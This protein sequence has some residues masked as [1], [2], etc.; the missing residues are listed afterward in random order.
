MPLLSLTETATDLTY[1]GQ[2]TSAGLTLV[3]HKDPDNLDVHQIA[4]VTM[5]GE[6][7]MDLRDRLAA[8]LT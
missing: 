1:T 8:L 4:P 2:G 6:T 3:V 7:W 5:T